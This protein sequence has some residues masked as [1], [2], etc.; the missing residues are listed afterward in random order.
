M[1]SNTS[2]NY[3][4][5]YMD[6]TKH[7]NPDSEAFAGGDALVTRLSQGW[8]MKK[9]VQIEQRILA[10]NRQIM[11]YHIELT[12]DG[13]TMKMPVLRNPYVNALMRRGDYTLVPVQQ[14]S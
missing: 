2:S 11:I 3:H 5:E 4:V 12:R 6:V 10:G 1:L 13:Q 8:Q 7:W 9:E 14:E